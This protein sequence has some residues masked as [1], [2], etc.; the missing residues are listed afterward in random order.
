[1]EQ[2]KWLCCNGSERNQALRRCCPW[3]RSNGLD[4]INSD[5]FKPACRAAARGPLGFPALPTHSLRLGAAAPPQPR[6]CPAA[7]HAP[8]SR[9]AEGGGGCLTS[10]TALPWQVQD[11]RRRPQQ[12]VS[13]ARRQRRFDDRLFASE[14]AL[15]KEDFWH[16]TDVDEHPVNYFR[17]LN[18]ELQVVAPA[19][20]RAAFWFSTSRPRPSA[21]RKATA[22]PVRPNN[23]GR[24][25]PLI[26]KAHYEV[27]AGL[28]HGCSPPP[29]R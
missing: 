23:F 19:A 3:M 12:L 17:M 11:G 28:R 4:S 2:E 9:A 8:P 22:R 6:A 29:L 25:A 13:A 24:V 16:A 26:L 10:A 18:G 21:A 7:L 27:T 5:L 15:H 20:A 14:V 1:M